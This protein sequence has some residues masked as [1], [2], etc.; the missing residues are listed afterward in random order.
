MV[1]F[2][3]FAPLRETNGLL[4]CLPVFAAWR[5]D[6]VGAALGVPGCASTGEGDQVITERELQDQ[7][8]AFAGRRGVCLSGAATVS[9][10][11]VFPCSLS[12][13]LSTPRGGQ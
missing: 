3:R 5:E 13:C 7:L 8:V 10:D 6:H 1:F 2:A 9:G 12:P 4:A 11:P